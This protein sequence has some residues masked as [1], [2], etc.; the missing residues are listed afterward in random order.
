[1]DGIWQHDPLYPTECDINGNINNVIVITEA[2]AESQTVETIPPTAVE[3]RQGEDDDSQTLR[4]KSAETAVISVAEA[5]DG[6]E[7]SDN[8]SHSASAHDKEVWPAATGGKAGVR[9]DIASLSCKSQGK[10][11]NILNTNPGVRI[12]CDYIYLCCRGKSGPT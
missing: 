12:Y 2:E 8:V 7:R 11:P 5:R 4:D 1:M 3:S 6:D 9:T 10:S